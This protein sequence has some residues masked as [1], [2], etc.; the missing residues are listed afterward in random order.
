MPDYAHRYLPVHATMSYT[1]ADN[2]PKYRDPH[3]A[4]PLDETL[5]ELS[6][7]ELEFFR[8]Q[9]GISN[10]HALKQHIVN[11]QRKAYSVST[12]V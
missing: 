12:H 3:K 5:Y 9:T 11:V 4:P 2:I 1:L 8:S 6:A 7:D 10:E